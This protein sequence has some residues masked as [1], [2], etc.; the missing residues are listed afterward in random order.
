MVLCG[1]INGFPF[2]ISG[3][4]SKSVGDFSSLWTPRRIERDI[5]I[6][7]MYNRFSFS[8]NS[9]NFFTNYIIRM[10]YYYYNYYYLLFVIDIC[11]VQVVRIVIMMISNTKTRYVH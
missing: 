11:T 8:D 6:I 4:L 2:G 9:N 10:Y 3:F 7:I 1:C 5:I